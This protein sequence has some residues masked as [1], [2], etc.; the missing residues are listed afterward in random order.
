[1]SH[2][3]SSRCHVC[4]IDAYNFITIGQAWLRVAAAKRERL[5]L[6]RLHD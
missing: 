1:M 3:A 4:V 5:E 2:V 6:Q